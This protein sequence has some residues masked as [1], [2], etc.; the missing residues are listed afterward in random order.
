M[1]FT[2]NRGVDVI[3]D[4]VGGSN[5]NRNTLCCALEARWILFGFLGG[6]ICENFD[7]GPMLMKR[8][9]MIP[10]TLKTRSDDYKAELIE[11]VKS[12]FFEGGHDFKT[13]TDK[14]FK[15]SEI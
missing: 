9:Q 5:A 3:A 8:I 11:Q 1:E 6:K 4:P 7:M 2:E 12:V 13:S 10:T 14:I 15:M